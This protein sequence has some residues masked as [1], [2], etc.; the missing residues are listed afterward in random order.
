MLACDG[1]IEFAITKERSANAT[2]NKVNKI[3]SDDSIN[4][5][6]SPGN[7]TR[8]QYVLTRCVSSKLQFLK[9]RNAE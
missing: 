2:S 8:V 9:I 4:L 7:P 5:F 1:R 6:T 3:N